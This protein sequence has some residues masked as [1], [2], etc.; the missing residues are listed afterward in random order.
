ML[1]GV[2]VERLLGH[3]PQSLIKCSWIGDTEFK[4]AFGCLSKEA[5]VRVSLQLIPCHGVLR[6]NGKRPSPI[7]GVSVKSGS[8]G[9][10]RLVVIGVISTDV[11]LSYAHR[12]YILHY[13]A[14]KQP[15]YHGITIGRPGEFGHVGLRRRGEQSVLID[16][17][18][19]AISEWPPRSWSSLG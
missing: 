5:T 18:S 4:H 8:L 9:S 13:V 12:R 16:Y 7:T 3:N 15:L 6:S 14:H 1:R 17:G 11:P 10:T 2:R 19:G